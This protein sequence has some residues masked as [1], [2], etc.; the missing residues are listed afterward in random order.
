MKS[1]CIIKNKKN[2]SFVKKFCKI[3]FE[4]KSLYEIKKNY[5]S[6]KNFEKNKL[7]I[8]VK[9]KNNIEIFKK[10]LENLNLTTYKLLTLDELE[11]HYDYN[12]KYY[13]LHENINNSNYLQNKESKLYSYEYLKLHY[14]D[15]KNF[16]ELVKNK[17]AENR[18]KIEII[19]KGD[20]Y[21][22]NLNNIVTNHVY[23]GILLNK[24]IRHENHEKLHNLLFL[25][26]L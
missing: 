16:I 13:G 11:K 23:L 5:I 1:L 4:K 20:K 8:S 9:D 12:I 21:I 14:E 10:H 19:N 17:S 25:M 7:V 24:K 22:I 6:Y 26:S 15:Y 3:K 18:Q 2:F